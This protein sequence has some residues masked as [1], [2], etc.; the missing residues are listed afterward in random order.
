MQ[1]DLFSGLPVCVSS[2]RTHEPRV[3]VRAS[4]RVCVCRVVCV[5]SI[6]QVFASDTIGC[7]RTTHNYYILKTCLSRKKLSPQ[8]WQ[9]NVYAPCNKVHLH[10][11]VFFFTTA[12]VCM[13]SRQI[14]IAHMCRQALGQTESP[15]RY[16]ECK[17]I[18]EPVMRGCGLRINDSAPCLCL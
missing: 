13:Y 18:Y 17:R 15:K 5:M 7:H 6:I 8:M 9:T 12:Y 16:I 11:M 14:H 4:L 2:L 10:T 1:L 3:F